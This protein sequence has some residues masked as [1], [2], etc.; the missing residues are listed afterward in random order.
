M[1]K[2]YGYL[3]GTDQQRLDEL[4]EA[5]TDRQVKAVF[6]VRGGYGTLRLLDKIAYRVIRKNPKIFLG[7]SDIT[8][9]QLAFLKKASLPSLHV[10]LASLRHEYTQD[11]FRQMV[12]GAK[13]VSLGFETGFT[14]QPAIIVP[15]KARGL[16]T[17][18]NLSLLTSL[19]CTDFL[20]SISSKIVFI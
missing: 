16:L 6:A 11:I 5:F 17:G 13:A 1:H 7:F 10:N 12:F 14:P 8:G 2:H 19:I 18:G 15:G 20:P 9:V 4:L 3:A